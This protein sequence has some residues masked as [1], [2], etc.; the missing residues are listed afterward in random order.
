MS[1]SERMGHLAASQLMLAEMQGEADGERHY[2]DLKARI[3][4]KVIDNIDLSSWGG[5]LTDSDEHQLGELIGLV[6][7]DE[8]VDLSDLERKTLIDDIKNEVVGLGP[9][10][11]LLSDP[12]INDILV[13]RYDEIFVE[14]QGRIEETHVRFRDDQH[15]RRII[16]RITS[17]VGRRID[18]AAPMIDARLA[19]GSRVNATIPPVTIDGPTLSIRKFA[20]QRFG[21]RDLVRLGTLSEETLAVLEAV[22][23]AK[24]NVIISGGTGSGKTTLL[25]VLS[26]FV[27]HNERIITVEDSAELQLQQRHVVRM[28]TRPPNL[29]NRGAIAMRELVRNS[30]RMRPD[31]IIVGE[32][33]GGETLDMLQAMNTG[34]DG[35]LCTVH[36]NSPRDALSRLETMI[37]M[38]GLDIPER[39]VRTQIAS[40]IQV[41]LQVARLSDGTRKLVS[42][43]EITGMEGEMVSMQ[44]I[45]SFKQTGIDDTGR[46]LGQYGPT[47]IRPHFSKRLEEYGLDL[48]GDLFRQPV[49]QGGW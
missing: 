21:A 25:N 35:S 28:E 20:L 48:D 4:Y 22:I 11:P 23:K 38:S 15:L 45:F 43:Q 26:A 46:V 40:A 18:E 17:A 41:V 13:N 33:R 3:H 36:A 8:A 49:A 29:E 12:T 1:F 47:G 42:F 5:D 14:R 39:S 30:L 37:A 24:L 32:V 31:R 2:Q 44:E 10:E 19:D 7:E 16:D 27:P 6:L 34:H 9:L